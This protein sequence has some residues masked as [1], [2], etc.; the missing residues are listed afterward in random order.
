MARTNSAWRR[1]AERSWSWEGGDSR[2]ASG[3]GGIAARHERQIN[4]RA[5]CREEGEGTW[6]DGAELVVRGGGQP[7]GPWAG[8]GRRYSSMG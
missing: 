4:S 1:S 5:T 7:G 3:Q 6:Q 8:V 2:E